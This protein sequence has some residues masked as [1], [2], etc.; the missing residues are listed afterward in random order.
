MSGSMR[1]ALI[2]AAAASA[3]LALL[4]FYWFAVPALALASGGLCGI[5]NA[6][7]TW[8][9]VE[10]LARTGSTGSFVFSSLL[11]IALF[12]I[13]PVAFAAA[14]P[15]WAMIWYFAG[16]LLPTALCAHALSRDSNPRSTS[17]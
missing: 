17:S 9:G 11:R 7:L 8:R 12:G 15:W 4:A 6:V 10:R 1:F 16:F 2:R 14:G 13:V 3:I 5:L